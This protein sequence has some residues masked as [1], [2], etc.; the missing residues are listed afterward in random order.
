MLLHEGSDLLFEPAKSRQG[1]DSPFGW[2][3]PGELSILA[4]FLG[5]PGRFDISAEM[6]RKARAAVLREI[7]QAGACIIGPRSSGRRT[8]LTKLNGPTQVGQLNLAG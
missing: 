7:P 5:L 4:G 1:S 6:A 8:R 3:M 2:R